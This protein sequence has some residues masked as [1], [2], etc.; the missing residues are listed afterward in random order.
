MARRGLLNEKVA[1]VHPRNQT[2]ATAVLALG[3][4]TGLC[5]FLGDAILVPVTEVGS[6]ASATG[7]LAACA[8]YFAMGPAPRQR[9]VAAAGVLIGSLM[10]LMKIVPRFPGALSGYEWLALIVW[11]VLGTVLGLHA[12]SARSFTGTTHRPPKK[13]F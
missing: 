11:M 4:A 7:W 13:E 2:P 1:A 10:I 6:V 3:I 5:M 12:S 8:A 9:L